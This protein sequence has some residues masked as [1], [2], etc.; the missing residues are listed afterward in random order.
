MKLRGW[1]CIAALLMAAG[2]RLWAIAELPPGLNSD[3]AFHLLQAQQIDRGGYFPV[4]ITGNDGNEPLMAYSAALLLLILGPVTW[5]GRLAMAFVG[6]IGVAA[7]IRAGQE[8]FP[9]TGVGWLAGAALGA[10]F[11][12]IDFSRFGS[13]PILVAT[14]AAG[15]LAAL[16]HAAHTGRRRSFVLA[17]VC[18]GLG[19]DS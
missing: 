11:W 19:L 8:M 3:E 1:L 15:C 14:A 9:R 12:N 18:L 13:Q 6:L 7:T 10:L 17:G 2:F 4:Y 16:W 5:A